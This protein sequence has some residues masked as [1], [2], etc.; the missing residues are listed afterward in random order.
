MAKT[1]SDFRS[2]KNAVRD[3]V[4]ALERG[5]TELGLD[6]GALSVALKPSPVAT[7]D[8]LAEHFESAASSCVLEE[9]PREPVSP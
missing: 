5:V 3:I 6:V 2:G 7:G 4:A 9:R 1:P 8:N